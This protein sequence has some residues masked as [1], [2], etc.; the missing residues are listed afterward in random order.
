MVSSFYAKSSVVRMG[1]NLVLKGR[2]SESVE[3]KD[4]KENNL[5][6]VVKGGVNSNKRYFF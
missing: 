4:S 2:Q 6:I 1:R 5:L 3:T